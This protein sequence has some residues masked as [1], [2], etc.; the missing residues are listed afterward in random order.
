MAWWWDCREENLEPHIMVIE[1]FHVDENGARMM[2]GSWFYRPPETY[3]LATRK[4]LE[5]VSTPQN[6]SPMFT[7]SIAFWINFE[8]ILFY[9]FISSL[10]RRASS[11]WYFFNFFFFCFVKR[12]YSRVIH[13]MES[14]CLR[15][16]G[17]AMLCL[18]RTTLNSGQR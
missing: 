18:S 16:W 7:R 11:L 17:D 13:P 10:A 4:F 15:S 1:S 14:A 6:F 12:R 8:V 2:K 3:H 5:K 9:L